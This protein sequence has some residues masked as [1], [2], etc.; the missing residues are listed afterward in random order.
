MVEKLN[1]LVQN[2][3]ILEVLTVLAKTKKIKVKDTLFLDLD[4][5]IFY[6]TGKGNQKNKEGK[7]LRKK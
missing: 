7:A 1:Q 4:S 5:I 6:M 2:P 3:N